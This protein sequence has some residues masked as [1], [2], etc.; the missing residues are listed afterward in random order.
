[1]QLFVYVSIV[2]LTLGCQ[3]GTQQSTRP[4][5]PDR[6]KKP[7]AGYGG[8][9]YSGPVKSLPS[10]LR[11]LSPLVRLG[12]IE[13]GPGV[14]ETAV[15]EALDLEGRRM[16]YQYCYERGVNSLPAE[17]LGAAVGEL[18]IV[19]T[20]DA[21]GDV[22]DAIIDTATLGMPEVGRCIVDRMKRF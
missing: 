7:V 21:L 4:D 18:W 8:L 16:L 14:G 19:I 2:C 17:R 11:G 22:S 1:M 6:K 9:G 20:V 15:R 12:S 13:P 5:S 3:A 10:H